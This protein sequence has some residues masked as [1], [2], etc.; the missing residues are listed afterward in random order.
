VRSI[1]GLERVEIARPGYAVEYEYVDPRRLNATLEA[2]EVGG[3]FLAGQINGTTGYEEAAAQGVVAGLNAASVALDREAVRFDRRTSYIGVMIDDLTL[4]GVSEPYRM[5]TA[6]AE[7]R[8]SLRAD[9]ATTRLGQAALA[10]DCVSPR[11]RAQI[12]DHAELR[13]SAGWPETAEARADALYRPYVERQQREWAVVQRDLCVWIAPDLDYSAV[14]GL[15]NE[16]VERLVAA[17]PE[18]LD[19]ASRIAGVTPAALSALYVATTRRA[20]A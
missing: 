17:R 4:Q 9:N 3:L 12:E 6:R 11:R 5:M 8:L 2:R 1:V 14:P 15:S 13:L 19:Q 10:A 7:H 18:T 16:M 20:A